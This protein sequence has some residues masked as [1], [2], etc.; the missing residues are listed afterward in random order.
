LLET[1]PGAWLFQDGSSGDVQSDMILQ[2]GAEINRLDV[3]ISAVSKTV[4]HRAYRI[5]KELAAP[6][7]DDTLI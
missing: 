6:N 4:F 2:I 7:D 3:S 1:V 5:V